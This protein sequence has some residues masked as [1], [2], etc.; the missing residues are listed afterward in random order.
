[1]LY[2]SVVLLLSSPIIS[3]LLFSLYS[4]SHHQE[5]PP[6]W[7][8]FRWKRYN[9]KIFFFMFA[10]VVFWWVGQVSEFLQCPRHNPDLKR[11]YI[12]K[13]ELKW[14]FPHVSR[15]LIVLSVSQL[16]FSLEP[17]PVAINCTAFNHNGNL[18]VTGAADGIIRLFGMSLMG[19]LIHVFLYFRCPLYIWL[20]PWNMKQWVKMVNMSG[21]HATV[22]ECYELESS[23]WGSLQCG[24]QLWWKHRLQYRRRWQGGCLAVNTPSFL[25]NHAIV[26]VEMK[27]FLPPHSL[28]SGT[29]IV[30]GWNSQSRL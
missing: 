4:A 18:L 25:K 23:W 24:V 22:W 5:G 27:Y 16:Q 29:F 19:R 9:Y 20:S 13:A 14:S 26:I 15:T 17:E 7:A 12:H 8:R 30:A 28:S 2:V 10:T 11:C 1:M 21:R 6:I 3:A